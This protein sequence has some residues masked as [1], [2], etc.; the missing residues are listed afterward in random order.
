M[1]VWLSV[2]HLLAIQYCVL[3]GRSLAC[4]GWLCW[5]LD[6]RDERTVSMSGGRTINRNA[7]GIVDHEHERVVGHYVEGPFCYEAKEMVSQDI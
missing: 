2:L 3:G 7:V 1:V 6:S 5:I 4:H